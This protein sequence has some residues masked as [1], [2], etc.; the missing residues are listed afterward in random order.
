MSTTGFWG[1]TWH[2]YFRLGLF[3]S[4]EY[5][6]MLVLGRQPE[7]V[8]RIARLWMG[9]VISAYMHMCGSW[10]MNRN[11]SP[12]KG[13]FMFFVWQAL[14]ITTQLL[15]QRKFRQLASR[16]SLLA[17]IFNGGFCCL[18]LLWTAPLLTDDLILGGFLNIQA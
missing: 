9:F 14:G 12:F 10:M 8:I 17:K 3:K 1:D 13:Q 15:L 11:G 7:S 16:H 6:V 5:L 4:S 2:S 18:W